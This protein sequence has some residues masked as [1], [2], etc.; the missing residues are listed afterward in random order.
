VSLSGWRKAVTKCHLDIDF[1]AHQKWN[2]SQKLPWAIVDSGTEPE[3]LEIE[4]T[5]AI[6][7]AAFTS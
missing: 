4:L 1:Y 5:R 3:K 6:S 2:T 7:Q